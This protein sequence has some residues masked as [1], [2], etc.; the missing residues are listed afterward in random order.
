MVRI[1]ALLLSLTTSL[2]LLVSAGAET[3]S[4]LGQAGLQLYSLRDEFKKDVPGTLDRVKAYGVT[5]VELAGFYGVPQA[6]FLKMLQDRGLQ[7]ISGHFQYDAMKKDIDSAVRD[8]KALGLKY[9]ACAWIPHTIAEFSEADARRAA[10]DFNTW[11]EAFHK[12]GIVFCYHPHGYEFKPH[13]DGTLLDV[14]MRETKP[15]FVSFEMDVFWVVHPGHDPV[16][17]LLKYPHRWSLMHLKDIRKGAQTGIYTGKAPL[18]DD[19]PLGT[20]MVQWPAVLAAAAESGVKHYFLEDE[21]PTA[22]AAI[23]ESLKYLETLKPKKEAQ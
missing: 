16:K 18:T 14:I 22:A 6:E 15:E 9:V 5:E 21:S 8:A 7:P 2:L 1:P 10:Q 11:G 13:G 23:A 12:E 3:P 4:F 19:V 20:G 17:L